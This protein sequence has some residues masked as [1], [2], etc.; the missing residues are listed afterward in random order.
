MSFCGTTRTDLTTATNLRAGYTAQNAVLP[1]TGLP[2]DVDMSDDGKITDS[3]LTSALQRLQTSNI[4]P[5]VPS[6]NSTETNPFGRPEGVDPLKTYVEK[7]DAFKNSLKAEYCWY[8]QAYKKALENFLDSVVA[9]SQASNPDTSSIDNQLQLLKE[10][11]TKLNTLTQ[12]T[13]RIA[14]LRYQQTRELGDSIN[15]LN[16]SL[17]SKRTSLQEHAKIFKSESA[18]ADLHK[19]MVEYTL[20]KNKANGNLLGLYAVLNLLALGLVIYIARK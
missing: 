13:N 4:I 20:E 19:R 9:A 18:A 15:Q 6:L 11:N 17:S 10:L 1:V 8:E 14:L 3:W 2:A 16:D 12:L 5:T 7:E